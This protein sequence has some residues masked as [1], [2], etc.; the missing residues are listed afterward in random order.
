MLTAGT[1][2]NVLR[3]LPPLVMPDHLLEEGLGILEKAIAR[4]VGNPSKR[5]SG[6]WLDARFCRCTGRGGE[7][8][9]PGLT[10][11]KT[12]TEATGVITDPI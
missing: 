2:G 5:A 3:F 11:T 6:L 8:F 12:I 9:H 4:S 7:R 10:P 1:Y